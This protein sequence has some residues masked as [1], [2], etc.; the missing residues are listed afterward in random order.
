MSSGALGDRA[1]KNDRIQAF[2]V[3]SEDLATMLRGVAKVA[4]AEEVSSL[5]QA[6][7]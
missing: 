1:K 2:V 5:D 4:L 3:F 6:F 7:I